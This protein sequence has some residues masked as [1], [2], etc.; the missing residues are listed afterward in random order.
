[1]SS[2]DRSNNDLLIESRNVLNQQGQIIR[3]QQQ[4]ATK[5]IRVTLTIAGLLLT[6]TSVAV[7][8]I[9]NGISDQINVSLDTVLDM[10]SVKSVIGAIM[11]TY[12]CAILLAIFALIFIFSFKVLSPNSSSSGLSIVKN[13]LEFPLIGQFTRYYITILPFNNDNFDEVLKQDEISFRPGID[14]DKT[15]ELADEEN[16]DQ[17]QKIAEYN[18][19]CIKKNEEI[20][21]Q[22][23]KFLSS[24]YSTAVIFTIGIFGLIGL[25]IFYIITP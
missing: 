25:V 11:I 5:I 12:I 15:S 23:R 7:S 2:S 18:S 4:Q 10:L 1:M 8:L 22:N 17:S 3:N 24:V 16:S 19:G 21:E 9:T 13:F 20:I 14:G 6:A